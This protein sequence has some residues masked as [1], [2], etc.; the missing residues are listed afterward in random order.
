MALCQKI[1]ISSIVQCFSD[2]DLDFKIYFLKSKPKV[3]VKSQSQAES[4]AES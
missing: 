1:V 4:Q 2:G 3:K